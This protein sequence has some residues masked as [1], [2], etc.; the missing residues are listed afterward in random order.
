MSEQERR[1]AD[2][3]APTHVDD[4]Q[5]GALDD[6]TAAWQQA[7]DAFEQSEKRY[8]NSSST[9][10][11]SSART[12]QTVVCCR[13]IPPGPLF[14][15]EAERGIGRN[16]AEFLFP[17]TRHLFGGYSNAFVTMGRMPG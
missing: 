16:L 12:I 13:S 2:R 6:I 14:G 4:S 5:H 15:Y 9:V 1:H 17:E 3:R 7:K 10:W 8:R 11:V